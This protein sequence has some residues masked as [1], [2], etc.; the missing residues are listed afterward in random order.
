MKRAK[1]VAILNVQDGYETGKCELCPLCTMSY[2][3]NRYVQKSVNCKIGFTPTSCP[4]V[5]MEEK[6]TEND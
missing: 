3:E 5:V 1:L 6:E 4:L 2:F